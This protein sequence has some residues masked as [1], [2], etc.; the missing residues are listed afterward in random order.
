MKLL[1][2]S[3]L[4]WAIFF[5]FAIISLNYRLY[6]RVK[7]VEDEQGKVNIAVVKQLHFLQNEIANGMAVRQQELFPEGLIFVHTN[8]A[9][10]WVDVLKT[11]KPNTDLYNNGRNEVLKSIEILNEGTT[12]NIFS[13]NLKPENGVFYNGW[14]AYVE[15]KYLE[16]EGLGLGDWGLEIRHSGAHKG[17]V[18]AENVAVLQ[19]YKTTCAALATAFQTRLNDTIA[20]NIF[21]ES[22]AGGIWT[23]DNV[24]AIAAL[25]R[26]AHL[27]KDEKIAQSI[28]KL[29]KNW[30]AKLKSAYATRLTSHTINIHTGLE[31]EEAR[32]CSQSLILCFLPELDSVFARKHYD[33]YIKNYKDSHFGLPFFREYAKNMPQ[34]EGDVDSGPVVWQVGAVASLMAQKAAKLNGDYA[35]ANALRNESECFGFAYANANDKYYL[36]GKIPIADCFLAW[37]NADSVLYENELNQ[38]F[39]WRLPFQLLSVLVLFLIVVLIKWKI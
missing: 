6:N 38:T 4:F 32:G 17:I 34:G 21:L 23:C 30:T 28:D 9:L 36:C 24:V 1:R 15:G 2:F 12:K 11:I 14:K 19:D 33:I 29:V 39:F 13:A 25:K 16:L 27:E 3:F 18:Q 10:A 22:Y 7:I 8:Y 31:Q 20:N 26:F 37:C 5:A 35:T